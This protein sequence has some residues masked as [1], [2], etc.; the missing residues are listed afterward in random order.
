M[1][2]ISHVESALWVIS[3]LFSLF[4]R[5]CRVVRDLVMSWL[6]VHSEHRVGCRLLSLPQ[7]LLD[8]FSRM[9]VSLPSPRTKSKSEFT[10]TK[11]K[12]LL[13]LWP[14]FT[15]PRKVCIIPVIWQ[16]MCNVLSHLGPIFNRIWL[17]VWFRF[18]N[19]LT[20]EKPC[21]HK[22]TKTL[23]LSIVTYIEPQRSC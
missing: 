9:K 19:C 8:M 13:V 17:Q 18:C 20:A 1:F 6:S 10:T 11:E 14:L 23:K 3:Y 5:S 7:M 15:Q 2:K 21:A 12:D 16:L 4:P 22:W